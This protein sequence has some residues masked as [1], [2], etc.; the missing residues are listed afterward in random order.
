MKDPGR[1]PTRRV[2]VGI[3]VPPELAGLIADFGR[4]N[5]Q[6]APGVRWSDPNDLHITLKFLGGVQPAV[7]EDVRS[8][9]TEIRMRPFKVSLAGAGFFEAAGILFVEALRTG[10]LLSLQESVERALIGCGIARDTRPYRP[11]ITVARRIGKR[12]ISIP[13]PLISRLD[14]FC[15]DLPARGFSV[16]GIT[17]YESVSGHYQP[18]QEYDLCPPPAPLAP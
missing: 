7:L 3:R 11:H 2:F 13:R 14:G 5:F 12:R 15:K 16:Q 1:F 9:L 8:R 18:L 6:R 17:L 4:A 10:E